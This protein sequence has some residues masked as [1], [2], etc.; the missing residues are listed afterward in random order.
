MN[1]ASVAEEFVAAR[2]PDGAGVVGN[3]V[4]GFAAARLAI[5]RPELVKGL[6]IIDGGGFVGR[7]LQ[8][9]MACWL[10]SRPRFL[11]AVYRAF[12]AQYM[13]ART[14]ADRRARQ[15]GI[16]TTRRDPGLRAVAELWHSFASPEHDLRADAHRITAPTLLIWGRHP[17]IP[18]K[19]ARW[20][21]ATIPSAELVLVDSGHLPHTTDPA[22]VA[23]TT[24]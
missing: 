1:L 24:R 11:R 22:G 6:V 9:R 10:M 13:R 7:P 17:V 14:D 12:S 21:Q 8:I 18:G 2:A 16:A 5:R 4:G 3:S 15:T 20:M 23:T 19:V